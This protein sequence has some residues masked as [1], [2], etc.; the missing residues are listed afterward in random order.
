M[1]KGMQRI[2]FQ[3]QTEEKI[4]TPILNL[5]PFFFISSTCVFNFVNAFKQ[6][7]KNLKI[8]KKEK[9]L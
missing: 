7:R 4:I 5:P 2:Y 3:K 1:I 6:N 9:L 8:L